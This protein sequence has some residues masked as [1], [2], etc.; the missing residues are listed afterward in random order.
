MSETV[1]V[2]HGIFQPAFSMRRLCQHLEKE[3]FDVLNLDY[4]ST[5]HKIEDLADIIRQPISDHAEK[6]SGKFH[7]VGF[8]MGGLVIRALLNKFI[9]QN[10]GRV[11][12]IGTPNKGSEI[13]DFLAS[14]HAFNLIYGPAGKQ[15]VTNQAGFSEIFKN[16]GMELGVIAGDTTYNPIVRRIMGKPSDGRVTVEST[17]LDCAQ[18]HVVVHTNHTFLPHNTDVWRHTTDF[19]RNG[20]FSHGDNAE[21]SHSAHSDDRQTV[22]V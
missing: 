22:A 7:L 18:D 2:L 4:P 6:S 21:H 5:S 10:L 14:Y 11:V 19:L 12:M 8:S 1:V 20:R 15:L 3:G 16:D 9:P 13:A 17:K